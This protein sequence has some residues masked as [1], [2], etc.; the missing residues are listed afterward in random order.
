[1]ARRCP[2][3]QTGQIQ[4]GTPRALR[5]WLLHVCQCVQA[6]ARL[7]QWQCRFQQPV[8]CVRTSL[9]VTARRA[10]RPAA[11]RPKPGSRGRNVELLVVLTTR[12]PLSGCGY[13]VHCLSAGVDPAAYESS[14][15]LMVSATTLTRSRGVGA[16]VGEQRA[17]AAT[18]AATACGAGCV[19]APLLLAALRT[20]WLPRR[21]RMFAR[22]LSRPTPTSAPTLE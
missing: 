18:A 20:L 22:S 4:V 12:V 14:D 3:A 13:E 17:A 10:Q 21:S 19:P 5:V 16:M 8:E 6:N 11:G 1:M 15:T 2:S 9:A 7:R